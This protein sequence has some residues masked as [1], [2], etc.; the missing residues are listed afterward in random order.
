M[1]R[2]RSQT[3]FT[4]ILPPELV[5]RC[6]ESLPFEEVHTTVKQVSKEVTGI[7]GPTMILFV[8]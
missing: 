6:L 1:P 4:R 7:I 3:G 2:L 5:E 8:K